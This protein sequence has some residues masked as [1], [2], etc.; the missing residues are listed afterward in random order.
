MTENLQLPDPAVRPPE[1]DKWKAMVDSVIEFISASR[2]ML[3][4][5]NQRLVD[6]E[7]CREERLE[8]EKAIIALYKDYLQLESK[9]TAQESGDVQF[10]K[11]PSAECLISSSSRDKCKILT[12]EEETTIRNQ[13]A[14]G[15]SS[16]VVKDTDRAI[17]QVSIEIDLVKSQDSLVDQMAEKVSSNE[18]QSQLLLVKNQK[19]SKIPRTKISSKEKNKGVFTNRTKEDDRKNEGSPI[20]RLESNKKKCSY[21]NIHQKNKCAK[22]DANNV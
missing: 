19:P 18:N 21:S 20:T 14:E 10:E 5:L 17:S 8:E 16:F 4:V 12:V 13:M 2:T 7:K 6:A 3:H 15:V 9:E 22:G 11:I 1:H